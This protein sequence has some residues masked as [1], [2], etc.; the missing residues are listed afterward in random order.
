MK[1]LYS[2]IFVLIITGCSTLTGSD[3]RNLEKSTGKYF[4]LKNEFPAGSYE[5]KTMFG[6]TVPAQMH[7]CSGRYSSLYRDRQGTYYKSDEHCLGEDTI[8]IWVPDNPNKSGYDIWL[9]IKRT[10][11]SKN[12]VVIDWLDSIEAG[13]FRKGGFKIVS[14]KILDM[15]QI[16][17]E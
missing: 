17:E 9:V 4:L 14:E 13:N 3:T 12:G 5:V 8:G 1:P 11:V 16:K 6:T 15:I 7:L 2:L 10:D